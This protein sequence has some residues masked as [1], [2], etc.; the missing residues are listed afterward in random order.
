M[1]SRRGRVS[2][3]DHDVVLPWGIFEDIR[4]EIVFE[5]DIGLAQQLPT[6]GQERSAR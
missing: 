2:L 6:S 4:I 5:I 1:A 3:E